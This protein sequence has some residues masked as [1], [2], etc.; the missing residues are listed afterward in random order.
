MSISIGKHSYINEPYHSGWYDDARLISGEK[1]DINIGKYTSIGKNCQFI[2]THHNY[3]SVSTHPDFGTVFSRGHIRIGNDVWIG[4]NVTIMD[5]VTIGDGAVIG[6]GSIVSS[7]IPPYAI[8]VGNPC[9]VVKYRF[10]EPLIRE[11]LNI[12]WWDLEKDEL[13]KLGIKDNTDICRFINVVE[14]Y[15]TSK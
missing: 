3:K 7:N 10:A 2:S 14:E 11:L 6:A 8:A 13:L 4:M 12:K 1:P 15:K 9:R 5:N